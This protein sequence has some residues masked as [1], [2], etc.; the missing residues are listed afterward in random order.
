[1]FGV[2]RGV[3]SGFVHLDTGVGNHLF[4][5]ESIASEFQENVKTLQPFEIYERWLFIGLKILG[6]DWSKINE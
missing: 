2:V 5:N 4:V 3:Q 6:F 1:M